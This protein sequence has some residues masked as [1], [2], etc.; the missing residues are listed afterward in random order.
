V[1]E[2]LCYMSATELAKAYRSKALSP[3]EVV[4]AVVRRAEALQPRLN[5]LVTLCA[6]QAL[7]AAARAEADFMGADSLPP[8]H[9][10]PAT[11][12]DLEDTAGVRTTYGSKHFA[13]HVPARDAIIWARMKAQGAI[14][15]GKT[16]TPEF[17][18]NTVG[19]SLLT[20]VTNNPWDVTRTTGGSSSGAGSAVAAGVGP[21]GT[22]SDGGGSIRVPSSFCG[23]VGLKATPGRIPYNGPDDA[24]E[25]VVVTGPMTRTVADCALMLDAVAGPDPYD[26]VAWPE[27]GG[28][29]LAGLSD[30]SMKGVRIAYCLDLKSGPVEQQVRQ[31]V[32]AAAKRFESEL[33]ARVTE[34]QIDLPDWLE[35]FHHWWGPYIM[36]FVEDELDPLGHPEYIPAHVREAVESCRETIDLASYVRHQYKVRTQLRTAFADIFQAY[37]LLIWPTTPSVAFPHPSSAGWPTEIEGQPLR[38]PHLDNQRFTE[39]ISHAGYPAI[40]VPAGFTREGLPIGLQIASRAGAENAIL[41]AAAAFEAIAPWAHL[42]PAC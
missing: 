17:G 30:L 33:G 2:D 41:R 4:E 1:S 3:R 18:L 9:G 6:E 32:E 28:G 15:I 25:G 14:L 19:E 23:L 35:Y 20:G 11:V 38:D 21:V 29:H 39:A 36:R 40:T 26:G 8:L 31:A 12:K 7:D 34:V 27:P 22:G 10:I 5:M 16:T 24:F 42:R 37:D 13:D